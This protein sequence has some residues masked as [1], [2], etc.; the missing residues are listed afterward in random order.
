MDHNDPRLMLSLVMAW[1]NTALHFILKSLVGRRRY[2]RLKKC[3]GNSLNLWSINWHHFYA[4]SSGVTIACSKSNRLNPKLHKTAAKINTE[5]L[6]NFRRSKQNK[7]NL[8]RTSQNRWKR[9]TCLVLHF[10]NYGLVLF[11]WQTV[12]DPEH[13]AYRRKI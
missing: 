2:F 12:R 10:M 1:W 9:Q 3:S 5:I 4:L 11:A 6:K 7:E 13:Q 8:S